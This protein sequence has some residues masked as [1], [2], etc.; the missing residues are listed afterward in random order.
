MRLAA[1][2]N[3]RRNGALAPWLAQK[4]TPSRVRAAKRAKADASTNATP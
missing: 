3:S 2:A 1:V 4:H